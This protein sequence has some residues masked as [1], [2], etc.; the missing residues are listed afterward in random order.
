MCLCAS[1]VND[2]WK[3]LFTKETID[4]NDL[5]QPVGPRAPFFLNACRTEG[6]EWETS[7]NY[8]IASLYWQTAIKRTMV[9]FLLSP[10]APV[11]IQP[12]NWACMF[13]C[14]N[15][16]LPWWKSALS[17]ECARV[18]WCRMSL[19]NSLLSAHTRWPLRRWWW[20]P[21][22]PSRVYPLFHLF[23]L[24]PSITFQFTFRLSFYKSSLT[25]YGNS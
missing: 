5:G 17:S 10:C 20:T 1:A 7:F 24:K 16:G 11:W 15:Q 21:V 12:V 13:A 6:C 8:K 2:L 23:A 3:T 19:I 14:F 9:P 22:G 25:F 4:S 18:P